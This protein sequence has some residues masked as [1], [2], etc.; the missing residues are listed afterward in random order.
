VFKLSAELFCITFFG[1]ATSFY[2]N[3]AEGAE[4]ILFTTVIIEFAS[5]WADIL[6]YEFTPL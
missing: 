6:S 1:V 5:I 4:F 2:F 3:F